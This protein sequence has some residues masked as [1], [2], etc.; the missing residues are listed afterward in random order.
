MIY[1]NLKGGFGNQL[2]QYGAALRMAKYDKDKIKILL[3][4]YSTLDN[5]LLPKVFEGSQTPNLCSQQEFI[6]VKSREK[7][8]LLTDS[9]RGE[10]F[11]QPLLDADLDIRNENIFLDGYFQSWKNLAALRNYLF[12]VI[13]IKNL[14]FYNLIPKPSDRMLC[15]HYRLGDYLRRDVQDVL[16][17]I[18]LGYVDEAINQFRGLYDQIIFFS[19]EPQRL[20][21]YAA[22]SKIRFEQGSS[23]IDVFRKIMSSNQTII[24]NSTFSLA[25][26]YLSPYVETLC[27]PAIWSRKFYIDELTDEFP[28]NIKCIA[29]GFYDASQFIR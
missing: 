6:S 26:A 11:D 29:N 14:D 18:K 27:R 5:F 20:A 28:S 19:D 24:P 21:G 12:N 15:V 25:A 7:I 17:V 2:I 3:G 13:G 10:F 23:T 8:F 16:G 9:A 22:K 1:L 4:N